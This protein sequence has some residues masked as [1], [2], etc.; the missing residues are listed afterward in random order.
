MLDKIR[1]MSAGKKSLFAVLLMAALV[2]FWRGVWGLSDIYLLPQNY[3]LSLW[4]SL[5]AGA[6]ILV[7]TGYL[8]K[9][10]D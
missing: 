9:D 3:E 2:L 4:I 1:K 6:L 5:V 10:L 8:A 7:A